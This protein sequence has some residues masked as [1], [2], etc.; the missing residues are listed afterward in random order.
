VLALDP[1]LDLV[2]ALEQRLALAPKSCA[3]SPQMPPFQST[4]V[5]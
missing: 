5:P 1:R 3:S 4:S 2:I